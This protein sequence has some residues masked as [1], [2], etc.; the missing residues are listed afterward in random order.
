MWLEIN[1][2]KASGDADGE[3]DK[4]WDVKPRPQKDYE[5]RVVIWGT[6]DLTKMDVEG[7]ND[8]FVRG[9]FDS[10]ELGKSATCKRETDTHYRC[11]NGLASFNYR[12]LY[13]VKAPA[14]HDD[15]GAYIYNIE[16]WD[17]DFFASNDLIGSA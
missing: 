11:S 4:V 9:S 1:P 14:L 15:P 8:V 13:D 16:C 5:V 2:V 17:R 10:A 7:T 6:K 3:S 12:F